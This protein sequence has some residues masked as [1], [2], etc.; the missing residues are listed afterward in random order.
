MSVGILAIALLVVLPH[1]VGSTTGV[2]TQPGVGTIVARTS[3]P[4]DVGVCLPRSARCDPANPPVT[5]GLVLWQEAILI[6]GLV[7]V[8]TV[9]SR[10]IR[11]SRVLAQ[12]P[13]GVHAMILRPPRAQLIS[14]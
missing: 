14:L 7:V 1:P 10:R 5:S 9:G 6:V 13:G 2:S 4:S 3:G 12:L 11:C 8:S